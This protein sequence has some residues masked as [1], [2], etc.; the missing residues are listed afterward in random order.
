MA[1][2][3]AANQPAYWWVNQRYTFRAERADGIMWAPKR[4]QD[5]R[6]QSH[7]ESMRDVQ[8]GDRIIH[9]VNRAILAVGVAATGAFDSRRPP[10]LGSE[11][12]D[13]EGRMV[14]VNYTDVSPSI[15]IDEIDL[16]QR[17][18][19][20][21]NQARNVKQGYLFAVDASVLAYLTGTF[22]QLRWEVSYAARF[23]PA[24]ARLSGNELLKQLVGVP[25]YTLSGRVNT[26]LAVHADKVVVA[27]DRSPAGVEVPISWIDE[28]L[29]RLVVEGVLPISV[30]EVGYRS[31]F[32]GAVVRKLPGA[33][34]RQDPATV[35][36]EPPEVAEETD[37]LPSQMPL[38]GDV[39]F[40]GPLQ[41]EVSAKA[42]REQARL[43]QT[44]LGSASSAN[45]AICDITYPVRFLWTA[46][47]KKHSRC[48]EEEARDLSHIAMVACLFGCDAL[49]EAGLISV[50]D[51]GRVITSPTVPDDTP[52]GERIAQLRGRSVTAYTEKSSKYFDWHRVNTYLGRQR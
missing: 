1:L 39:L 17:T 6:P 12:W 21:F 44:L 34:V 35:T 40:T 14:R 10:S 8:P 50:D 38:A 26:I 47:I 41:R 25:L 18:A 48:S 45:C 19:S 11:R 22:K 5:G 37:D 23:V 15:E 3:P 13:E 30:D 52:L 16:A 27:T 29:K 24:E 4:G 31:A 36:F 7:W 28:A 51:E 20:P 2:D 42:R 32:I 33:R 9:Y 49:Y 46:H 43:R